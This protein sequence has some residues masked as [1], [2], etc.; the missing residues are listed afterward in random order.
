MKRKYS[1]PI[2][3]LFALCLLLGAEGATRA[4]S[5]GQAAAGSYSFAFDDGAAKQ[6]DFDAQN[7]ADGTT[8]GSMSFSDAATLVYR[9]VDGTGDPQVKYPG[10]TIK[11]SFDGLN[12]VNKN[13]AVMSGTVTDSDVR[14]LIGLRVLLTVEDNGDGSRVPDQL[15]WGVYKVVRRD[16]TPSDAELKDDPGVGLTWTATDAERR[17]D[18]GIK[19]PRDESI[20]INSFPVAAYDFADVATQSGDIRVAP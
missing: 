16:W 7:L 13:Q 3:A 18:V 17:D 20:T 14:E 5:P 4:Q 9:D 12:V 6:L 1:A 15:T 8:S 19:M 2:L 11:A 10:F